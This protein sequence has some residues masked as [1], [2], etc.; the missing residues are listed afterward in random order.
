MANTLITESDFR[1]LKRLISEKNN[2]ECAELGKEITKAK[3]IKDE[4][5]SADIVRLNAS[6]DVLDLSS[7]QKLQFRIVMPDEVDIR[8]RYISVFAPISVAL[9]G[10]KESSVVSWQTA[11]GHRQIKVLKVSQSMHDLKDQ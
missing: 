3:I 2:K 6:V 9:L 4:K 7:G 8:N 1:I 5:A 11:S 10:Q